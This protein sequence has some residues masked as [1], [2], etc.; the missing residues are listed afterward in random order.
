VKLNI[1]PRRQ[2]AAP[3]APA[4]PAVKPPAAPEAKPAAEPKPAAPAPVGGVLTFAPGAVGAKQ[5]ATFSVT[6]QAAGVTDLYSTALR[7][8]YDPQALKLVGV[9]R[10][11]LMAGDGQQPMFTRNIQAETGEVSVNIVRLPGAGGVNG[12]G[13]LASLSFQAVKAGVTEVAIAEVS[14]R[15]SKQQPLTMARPRLSVRIE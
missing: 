15:D 3:A 5:G 4:A 7:V 9:E 2:D 11:E 12:V 10:G 8:K 13:P 6:L 14:A 1:A